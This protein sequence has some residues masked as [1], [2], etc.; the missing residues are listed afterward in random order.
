MEGLI[1]GILRHASH[2]NYFPSITIPGNI[3]GYLQYRP[4]FLEKPG[5]KT[6]VGQRITSGQDD[7]LSAQTFVCRSF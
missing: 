1:F 3:S 6:V 2:N 4:D 5:L 7:Y